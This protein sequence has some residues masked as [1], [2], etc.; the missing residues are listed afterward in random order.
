MKVSFLLSKE[1]HLVEVTSAHLLPLSNTV[2]ALRSPAV[3]TKNA[4]H[5]AGNVYLISGLRGTW[6]EYFSLKL[7]MIKEKDLLF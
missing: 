6:T 4:A 5:S 2:M 7:R 3:L 1:K